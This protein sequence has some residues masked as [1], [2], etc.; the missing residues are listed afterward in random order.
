VRGEASSSLR[1]SSLLTV[2]CQSA[3]PQTQT[4][5]LPQAQV[6][7]LLLLLLL[8]ACWRRRRMVLALPPQRLHSALQQMQV[9]DG[10][11]S[12]QPRRHAHGVTLTRTHKK[13]V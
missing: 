1:S 8:L 10:W 13:R 11:M 3:P 5:T 7:L 9:W 2:P 6:L 12:E 4:Q